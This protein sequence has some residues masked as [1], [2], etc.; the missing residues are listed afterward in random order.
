MKFQTPSSVTDLILIFGVIYVSTYV[1]YRLSGRI[2]HHA[3]AQG[4]LEVRATAETWETMARDMTSSNMLNH[5]LATIRNPPPRFLNVTYW[6]MRK[7][8]ESARNK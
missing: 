7:A 2:T 3:D 8:E 5:A 6:P 4:N 1:D